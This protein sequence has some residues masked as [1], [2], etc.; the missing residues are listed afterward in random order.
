M[1]VGDG[2]E[3]AA[4]HAPWSDFHWWKV[5]TKGGL[6][7]ALLGTAPVYYV[8]H[9]DDGR[10]WPCCTPDCGMCRE[11]K[12]SQVRY[13]MGAADV[14]TKRVGILEVGRANGL[15]IRDW[16][17]SRGAMKGVV[18]ELAKH[19]HARTSRTEVRLVD[20]EP[21]P[22]IHM[23]QVPDLKRALIL[24]WDKANMPIPPGMSTK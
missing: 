14:T 22:W 5:P 2:W 11:G 19:S 24:T 13:V 21:G 10:M 17:Q 20:K 18:I 6:M 23:L 1:A 4:E 7:L 16:A 8:G 3:V 9:F 12:G 15:L